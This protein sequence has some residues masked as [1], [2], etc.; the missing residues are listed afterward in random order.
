ME[1][2]SQD[3]IGRVDLIWNR[4]LLG[5]YYLHSFTI[6]Y[7]TSGIKK[8]KRIKSGEY[9]YGGIWRTSRRVKSGYLEPKIVLLIIHS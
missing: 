4:L 5:S 6:Q 2:R 7:H 3:A 8:Q 9:I 1:I